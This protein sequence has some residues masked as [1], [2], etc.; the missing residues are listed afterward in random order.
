MSATDRDS[1]RSLASQRDEMAVGLAYLFGT[2]ALLVLLTLV[3]PHRAATDEAAIAAV[4]GLALVVSAA[5]LVAGRGLPPALYAWTLALGAVL[6]TLCL[7]WGGPSGRVYAALYVWV[8]LYAFYFFDIRI[9]LLLTIW[10]LVAHVIVLEARDVSPVPWVD[11]TMVFGTSLVAGTLIARLVGQVR[12]RAADLDA[13][14]TLANALS[15]QSDVSWARRAICD[16]AREA[17]RADVAVLLEAGD[18]MTASGDA[19]LGA[20]LA[21]RPQVAAVAQS[22]V[23]AVLERPTTRPLEPHVDGLCHPVLLDGRPT[24]ALVVG[25]ANP[26]RLI[27]DRAADAASLFAAEATVA[28]EREVRLSGERE[29]RALEINDTVVQGLVVAKYALETGHEAEGSEAVGRTLD[30]ARDADGPPARGRPPG[31]PRPR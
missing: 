18:R 3:L 8:A 29:R 14:T 5:L 28:L 13:A 30:R 31:R 17:C 11:G 26:R 23:A 7:W 6:V 12:G 27:G 22:G 20:A 24:G 10:S 15:A 19:V 25:W 1:R 4:A 21:E 2:G 16:A 9:A